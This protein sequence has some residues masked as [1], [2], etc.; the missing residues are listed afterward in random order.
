VK[1]RTLL[2]LG[3]S[4]AAGIAVSPLLRRRAFAAPFGEFP[5]DAQAALLPVGQ[6][7]ESVLEIFL[8]G[9]LSAWE[10]LYLVQSYGT[11]ADAEFPNTQYHALSGSSQSALGRCGFPGGEPLGRF[12]ARDA[13][14]VDVEL[15][16]MA[17]R[18]RNLD[19][20]TARMRLVVQK[21]ALEP[22]EAAV[23]QALTGKPVGQPSA[24]GL[25]AHVQRFNVERAAASRAAPFSY[26]FATGGVAGDNVSAATNTGLH[27]GVARPL[28]VTITNAERFS[29][30][31]A[32]TEVGARRGEYDR[33]MNSYVEQYQ[34][35]LRWRGDGEPV[36]SAHVADL[37]QAAQSVADADAIASVMDPSLFEPRAGTA[38]EDSN[39]FDVPGMS[40]EAARHLLTHP[41][42]PARYVCVSDIGLYE[43]SGGGGYDTHT[44]N[45]Y[46]TA[47]N[48]DNVIRGLDRI[49]NRP[50]E[51][52]ATKLDLDRTLIIFNT[53]F[54]RT[55]WNQDGGNGRNHHPYGYVTAFI[56]GPVRPGDAGIYGAI[57]RDGRATSDHATP[58]EN[59]I[60]ALLSLGI[61]PFSPEAFAVSDVR[62]A[63][64]EEGAAVS[65]LERLLGVTP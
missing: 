64:S 40:L 9:G 10:T 24:A 59:R 51:V 62:D 63:T 22:H 25:G 6:R 44:D 29:Q 47:R 42:Q 38:C 20:L 14:G 53:E 43:A 16:P 32:R 12:F 45:A 31:L 4:A 61:W 26:L 27:P 34:R 7:A 33:L 3:A 56:G 28:Q 19:H 37:A 48:F 5:A 23:P 36:R 55:P 13:A 52:D 41:D 65:V 35:R 54:G 50:G 49:V 18:L 11:A 39:G 17:Y 57:G 2:K 15:G 21:H 46:D 58:A 1:R 8:Y 30:L 60:A